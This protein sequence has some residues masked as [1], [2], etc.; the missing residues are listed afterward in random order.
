MAEYYNAGFKFAERKTY[1]NPFADPKETKHHLVPQHRGAGGW[2]F[3][4]SRQRHGHHG[5][6]RGGVCLA[7]IEKALFWSGLARAV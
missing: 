1:D 3:H 6:R 5:V 4:S 7:P 2:N